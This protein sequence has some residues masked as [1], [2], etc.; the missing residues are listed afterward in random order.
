MGKNAGRTL[1]K[2]TAR[3]V[4]QEGPDPGN[5]V[6]I[7][8]FASEVGAEDLGVEVVEPT[9]NIEEER[10]DTATWALEG[11]DRVGESRAG[12]KQG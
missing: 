10:G 9:L 1:G 2:Q 11:T 8:P 12:V 3:A 6:V 5:Q 4:G 7:D